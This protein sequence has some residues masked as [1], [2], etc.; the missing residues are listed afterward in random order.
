MHI[1]PVDTWLHSIKYYFIAIQNDIVNVGL[2]LGEFAI[3]RITYSYISNVMMHLMTLIIEHHGAIN[4]PL[5]I[6]DV[7]ESGSTR[8]TTANRGVR[9]NS[10]T[11]VFLLAIVVE[12]RL[13][14][15]F[16]L[17]GFDISQNIYMGLTGDFSCIF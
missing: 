5:V 3:Y 17:S 2:F 16:S 12:E 9:L 13:K 6:L 4:K 7:M 8:T 11:E 14:L 10:T 1:L 15:R